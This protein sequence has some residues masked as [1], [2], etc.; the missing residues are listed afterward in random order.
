MI[1]LSPLN[2]DQN[3][4]YIPIKTSSKFELEHQLTFTR[5][6]TELRRCLI[7]TSK[8]ES[9]YLIDFYR[10]SSIFR[11][12]QLVLLYQNMVRSKFFFS[13]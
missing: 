5:I 1:L 8:F 9:E 6:C 12:V 3:L 13:N 11:S 7:K 10:T 2:V 4:F